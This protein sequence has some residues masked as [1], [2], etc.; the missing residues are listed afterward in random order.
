[1]PDVP[2][3]AEA[4][5]AGAQVLIWYGLVAPAA[6]PREV[7]SRLNAETVKLMALPDIRERFAQQAIDPETSTP[8]QFGKLIREEYA[9]WS[10]VI[11]TRGIKLE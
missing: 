3:I 9:R 4:G 6:T 11:R 8:E 7:V 2:T 10:K 5:L 1:L